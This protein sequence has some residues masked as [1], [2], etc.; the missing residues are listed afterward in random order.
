MY[1]DRQSLIMMSTTAALTGFC[2]GIGT[3]LL[4]APHSGARTR[5]QLKHFTEDVIDD[6]KE[7]IEEVLDRGKHLMAVR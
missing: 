7:A 1:Y 5:R 3:G 2:F 6:T 4:L